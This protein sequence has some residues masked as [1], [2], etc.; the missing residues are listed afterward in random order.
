MKKISGSKIKCLLMAFIILSYNSIC[1]AQDHDHD[2]AEN[3]KQNAK[4]IKNSPN[5]QE[6]NHKEDE[7]HE[8]D[9]HEDHGYDKEQRDEEENENHLKLSEKAV[10]MA[11]IQF[12]TVKMG[13]IKTHISLAGEVGFDEDHLVHVVPRFSGIVR[14]VNKR[15]GDSVKKGEV[16]AQVESNESLS[17]YD[18]ISSS[19]GTIIEK[20]IT[21]GEHVKDDSSV[22]VVVD[23]S[24]VWINLSIYSKDILNIQERQKVKISAMGTDLF[25]EGTICYISPSFNEKSRIAKARVILPN[26]KFYWRPGMFV[27]GDIRLESSAEVMIIKKLAPQIL[28]EASV[29]FILE[30]ENEFIPVSVVLGKSDDQF[31]EVIKGLN[32]GDKYVS[33]GAFELKA[34][35]VTGSLSGHAGHGH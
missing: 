15:L 22:Y 8:E 24:T 18:I 1:F 7:G 26:P 11:D 17:M 19:D 21:L 3:E 31:V 29:V 2:H 30:K 14:K 9:E 28:N 12:D 25:E 5:F 32:V 33:Q 4:E 35:I 34:E 10:R 23:L 16:L 20:H 27:K 6:N 13:K